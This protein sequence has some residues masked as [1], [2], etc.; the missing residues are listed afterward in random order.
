[1]HWREFIGGDVVIS[2][3]CAWQRLYNAI[4][5]EAIPNPVDPMIV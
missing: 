5:I 1:M 4:G 2:P 3:P